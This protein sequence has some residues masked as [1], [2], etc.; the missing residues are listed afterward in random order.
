MFASGPVHQAHVRLGRD[1]RRMTAF[2]QAQLASAYDGPHDLHCQMRGKA[3]LPCR[4]V[5]K[6]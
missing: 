4:H 6:L 3:R 5:L 2:K 1:R